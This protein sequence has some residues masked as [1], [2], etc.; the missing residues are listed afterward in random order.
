MIKSLPAWW[1]LRRKIAE[2]T[3]DNMIVRFNEMRTMRTPWL[4]QLFGL[5]LLEVKY[6]NPENN[7]HS[8]TGARWLI[9]KKSQIYDMSKPMHVWR[10]RGGDMNP[11]APLIMW[12]RTE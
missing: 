5:E 8:F 9:R 1:I 6:T 4:L 3:S 12:E 7:P 2:R 10:I 11:K